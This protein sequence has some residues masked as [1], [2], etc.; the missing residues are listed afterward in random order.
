[1]ERKLTPTQADLQ[2]L[3][4]EH[5]LLELL[6]PL[7]QEQLKVIVMDRLLT[8]AEAR[9]ERV[10]VLDNNG[11]LPDADVDKA[12]QEAWSKE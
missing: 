11:D 7:A 2:Q 9:K 8:E 12:M 10:A 4:K 3:L 1:M 6:T 5:P